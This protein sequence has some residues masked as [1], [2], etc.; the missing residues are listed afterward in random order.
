MK[1]IRKGNDITLTWTITRNGAAED[2][3]GKEVAVVLLDAASRPCVFSYTIDDNVITGTYLGKDQEALGTYTLLLT[4]NQGLAGMT[5]LD[6]VEAF[7][8]VP[9][10]YMEDGEDDSNINTE[11]VE[12]ESETTVPRNGLSAY[13][14][15]VAEGYEGTVDEWLASLVGPQGPQGPQG[16]TG[17]TGPQ[18]PKGDTGA[19]GA[20]GPKGDKGDTGATGPTGPTGPQG[21]QG[22]AGSDADVTAANIAAALGYTPVSPTLLATKQDTLESGVNIKTINNQSLLGNGNIDIQGGGGD[23]E[24]VKFTPQTL[25]EVQKAQARTNIEAASNEQVSQLAQEVDGIVIDNFFTNDDLIIADENNE[26]AIVAFG[27]GEI[28]TKK[29]DSSKVK[30]ESGESILGDFVITDED[31]NVI[32]AFSDGHIRTKNFNSQEIQIK[33]K[34]YGKKVSIIGDSISTAPSANAV[35]FTVLDSDIANER[36]LQGYPTYYDIGTT[37]GEKTV[38][39]SM[40]G[41]LTSFTPVS[42]DAGK[43]IGKALNYNTSGASGVASYVDTWWHKLASKLGM[44]VL[45]NVSWSGASISSHEGNTDI[46]KTSYAW[47]PAQINKLAT[48]DSDGNT[49]NPDVVIIYRGTNDMTH[50]P[51]TALS[52]FG[53]AAT[54]IPDTDYQDSMYDFKVA[55]CLTIKKIREAYPQAKIVLC[56]LNVFKRIYYSQFPTNNGYNTLPEYNNAIRDVADMMGCGLIEFD[57]DGIT[58]ENCYPAYI[59]DS[60]TIPTHPNPT[61][62]TA[63]AEKATID[64]LKF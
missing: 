19:T 36:T 56:T 39:S 5:T 27:D 57:K 9:H 38:D 16:A 2:F 14:V 41:V 59:S 51:Y 64:I 48:R 61:G 30:F 1:Y 53:V 43:T 62:H 58:F 45:Q 32:V 20:T 37:I 31:G 12:L 40:V 46:Y 21:P 35:E 33:T 28:R 29:F 49:I 4:E 47:H 13:E 8:L 10:S 17:A 54:S 15:A 3:A 7:S 34:W 60:S 55:Y 50:S 11:T 6:M 63:M 44:E 18:G 26:N 22:P 24:A 52:E 42:G 23:P 25:T